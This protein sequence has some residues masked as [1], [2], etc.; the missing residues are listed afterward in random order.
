MM[1]LVPKSASRSSTCPLKG[2]KRQEKADGS[3]PADV[4]SGN[5]LSKTAPYRP[6]VHGETRTRTGDI[7]SR[8]VP[9]AERREIA[10]NER[11]LRVALTR[12]IAFCAGM[13]A[14]QGMAGLR[15]PVDEGQMSV[16]GG[17]D[18]RRQVGDD[19]RRRLAAA[20]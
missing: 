16:R 17:G 7:F 19:R 10:G 12:L 6:F 5:G 4:A 3:I 8:Y 2:L 9:A 13:H 14:I 18:C 1:D 20:Y 15:T 11:F